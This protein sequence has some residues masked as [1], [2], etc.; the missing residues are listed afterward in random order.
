M[1]GLKGRTLIVMAVNMM[2]G[3]R[4][5]LYFLLENLAEWLNVFCLFLEERD[6]FF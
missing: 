5:A 6:F 4:T 3:I 2:A 1:I